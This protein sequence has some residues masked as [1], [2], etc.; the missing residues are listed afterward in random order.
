MAPIRVLLIFLILYFVGCATYPL[1][2]SREKWEALSPV[3]QA[4]ALEEQ[5]RID[6]QRRKEREAARAREAERRAEVEARRLAAVEATYADP[7]YGDLI[8]VKIE[9]G[10]IAFFGKRRTYEPMAFIIAAWELKPIQFL[11]A[12]DRRPSQPIWVFYDGST[13]YFDVGTRFDIATRYS[14]TKRI[15]IPGGAE[16]DKGQTYK[17][18]NLDDK[19][20]SEA[21]N[22][23]ITI[24]HRP[25]GTQALGQP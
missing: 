23:T 20:A 8:D 4:V 22:I 15:T 10:E 21:K 25:L 1:G 17:P 14:P 6:Q 11:E 3:E 18:E 24:R 9:G 13:F 16:W 5:E 7:R 2:M 19:T 12:K